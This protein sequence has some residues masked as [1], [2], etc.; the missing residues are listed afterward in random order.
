MMAVAPGC[1]LEVERG[2]DWL[3]VKVR[4][5]DEAS[6]DCY[7]LAEELLSLMERHLAHR[8][9]LEL[10]E[11]RLLNSYVIGQLV[12]LHKMVSERG[13]LVRLCG[14]SPYNRR[15]LGTCH[16]DDVF[17]PYASRR[18]AILGCS[19]PRNPR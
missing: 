18:E 1:E 9:C 5:L 19:P 12:R 16:L 17:L 15:V 10:D 2:P 11:L 14:L 13:G 8:L 7:P 3:M 6:S 4:G